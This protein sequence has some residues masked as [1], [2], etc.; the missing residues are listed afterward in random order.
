MSNITYIYALIDPK[1]KQEFHI[2]IGKSDNPY[3]RYY[4][5]IKDKTHTLKVSWIKSLLQQGVT[6]NIQIL[7]IC[8]KDNWENKEKDWIKFYRNIKW[9]VVNGTDGGEC[10]PKSKKGQHHPPHTDEFK[11][12]VS[13]KMMNN[14]WNIGKHRTESEKLHLSKI[15]TGLTKSNKTKQK[16]RDA[17]IGNKNPRYGKEPWNKGL[18]I[19]GLKNV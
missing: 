16:M 17:K 13:K 7:E 14:T 19:K 2:Y 12:Q 8:N 9:T 3:K 6:P 18:Y 10:G 11:K 15:F 5:H 1:E 4:I